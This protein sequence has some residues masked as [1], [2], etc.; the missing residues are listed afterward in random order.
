M[1]MKRPCWKRCR[2]LCISRPSYLPYSSPHQLPSAVQSSQPSQKASSILSNLQ[3]SNRYRKPLSTLT[4][5]TIMHFS[6]IF[7]GLA[8]VATVVS[9]L[10][11]E[12][13]PAV[14]CPVTHSAPKCCET[15][16][17]KGS[18]QYP[19]FKGLLALI[20]VVN[21]GDVLGLTCSAFVASCNNKQICCT[22]QVNNVQSPTNA[23]ISIPINA[24]CLSVL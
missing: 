4:S 2:Y 20:G 19:I 24:Q 13:T 10:P 1:F 16:V 14:Q 3:N 5:S 6:K 18:L 12:A 11:T 23:L 17:T 8:T 15:V 9:A 7:F 22:N 21:V